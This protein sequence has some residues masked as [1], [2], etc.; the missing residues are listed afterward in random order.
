MGSLDWDFNSPKIKK[1]FGKNWA[2][3]KKSHDEVKSS[4]IALFEKKFPYANVNEFEWWINID[5]ETGVA[6][7][8]DIRYVGDKSGNLWNLNN[9]MRSYSYSVYS[10]DFKYKYRTNLFWG[11]AGGNFQ[12]TTKDPEELELSEGDLGFDETRFPLY[13]TK[14]SSFQTNF[15]ALET[16]WAGKED[17]ITKTKVSD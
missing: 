8:G 11:P 13:V 7:L 5:R 2:K 1:Y 12:P 14:T 17:D 6:K 16:K 10:N 4:A 3:A 9:T 15:P